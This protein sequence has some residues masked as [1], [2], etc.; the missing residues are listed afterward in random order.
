MGLQKDFLWGGAIAANQCEGAWNVGGKGW[1]VEDVLTYKPD[2]DNKD[3]KKHIAISTEAI[4]KAL[5]DTDD[6]FYPKR[7]GIDFYHH[8]KEDLALTVNC[9]DQTLSYRRRRQA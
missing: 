2:T 6:T 8:F 5:K 9:L 4:E 7:R 3:Y 1:S